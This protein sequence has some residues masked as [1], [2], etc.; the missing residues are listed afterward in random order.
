MPALVNAELVE[1]T[2]RRLGALPARDMVH[3]QR[4]SGKLQ[5]E[6]VGFVLGFTSDLSAE[7]VG[8]TLYVMLVTLEMF[9]TAAPR[10]L[11]KVKD[12]AIMRLWRESRNAV[13]EALNA[14]ASTDPL[15][16]L[17]AGSNEPAVLEY[18]FDALTDTEQEEPVALSG[19]ELEHL[20]AVLRTFVEGLHLASRPA[21]V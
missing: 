4:Q 14:N 2:W 1:Y 6:L 21:S 15:I 19:A 8:L 13:R 5:P 18:V 7:A 12:A 16:V 20:L 11:R 17:L 3:L 9:R 10:K